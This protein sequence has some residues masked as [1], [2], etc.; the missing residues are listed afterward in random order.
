MKHKINNVDLFVN[1]IFYS[2]Q[3]EGSHIG[4]PCI[5]VRMQGCNLRCKWCDTSYAQE[6]MELY[7][8]SIYKEK[9]SFPNLIK[10]KE[11]IKIIKSYNCKLICITGGE[12]LVQNETTFL[13]KE[14]CNLEYTVLVETNGSIPILCIDHRASLIMD[15]KCPSSG[16]TEHIIYS[17]IDFLTLNDE[18]K[19]VIENQ[20]DY[21]WAKNLI[22]EYSLERRVKE[23]LISPVFSKID[24]EKLAEWILTDNLPVRLQVQLHK[25]IWGPKKKGV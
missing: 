3:G 11:L 17:N 23:I 18:I 21:L 9:K 19:F 8:I 5:F 2:I 10:L 22:K 25:I 4:M 16:M 13:I 7:P 14:L 20:E 1:E 12:P 15:L 6:I 24:L